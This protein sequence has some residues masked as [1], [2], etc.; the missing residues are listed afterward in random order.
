MS[1]PFDQFDTFSAPAAPARRGG[2]IDVDAIARGAQELGIDPVDLATAISYETG[3]TFDPDQWGPTTKWGRHRGLIQFGEPQ[4]AQYGVRP[5]MTVAEQM[6]AVV[7]YLRDAGVQPGMGML[8][9]YSAINAGGVGR[10]N[11]SDTAA[12][13]APGTVA[14]KVNQQMGDHRR[15]AQQLLGGIGGGG[16]GG[17]SGAMPANPF[18]QF[19]NLPATPDFGN[20]Q[21]GSRSTE[22][23]NFA[24]VKTAFNSTEVLRGLPAL[25]G[26]VLQSGNG[27][28]PARPEDREV[29][30]IYTDRRGVPRRWMGDS[31]AAGDSARETSLAEMAG[32]AGIDLVQGLTR[33]PESLLDLIGWATGGES[34]LT[35]E[36]KQA[37]EGSRQLLE[38]YKPEAYRAEQAVPVVQRDAQ[39]GIA[40]VN[41]PSGESVLGVIAQSLP[42]IPQMVATG[43]GLKSAAQGILPN[44]PRL[45]SVLGYGTANAGMVSPGI[46]EQ[47]RAEALAAGASPEEAQAVAN[48]AMA[49]AV[50]LTMATGGVGEGLA[51]AQGAGA[52]SLV[53]ALLRGA[54][55]EAPAESIEEAGTSAIGD[56]AQGRDVNQANALESGIMAAFGGGIP[57]ATVAGTEYVANRNRPA[58]LPADPATMQDIV[59]Q[60]QALAPIV[61]AEAAG[62]GAVPR[63]GEAPA[64]PPPSAP[65]VDAPQQV[66]AAAPEIAP[67]PDL[68]AATRAIDNRLAALDKAAAAQIDEAEVSALNAERQELD[69]LLREQDRA[70]REGLIQSPESRLSPDERA[71]ADAR[72]TE[73]AATLE[74]HR[75]ARTAADQADRL[76]SRLEAADTDAALY[77]VAR[78]IDPT[79]GTPQAQAFRAPT[80]EP[81]KI[82][83]APAVKEES[84]QIP[85]ASPPQAEVQPF[86][87]DLGTGQTSPNV[88]D[89]PSRPAWNVVEQTRAPV[90]SAPP[91]SAQPST[92]VSR[93]GNSTPESFA[94]ATETGTPVSPRAES[95]REPAPVQ[96][97]QQNITGA[98]TAP[99]RATSL[100]NAVTDSERVAEGRDPIIREARKGNRETVDEALTS[101]RETPTLGR[102]T[103]ARVAAGGPVELKDE[104]VLLVH[105]VDLRKRRDAAAE[106]AQSPTLDDEAR[107]AA[108][109]EYEDLVQQ[110]D[111]VD[112][113]A[114]RIGTE[115]GRLLQLRR[116]MIAEDYSLPALERKLRMVVNRELKPGEVTELREMADKVAELQR[117]LDAAESQ[118]ASAQVAE[119]LARLMKQAPGRNAT[120]A[121]RRAAAAESRAA[122]SAMAAGRGGQRSV[123]A[124]RGEPGQARAALSDRF[125]RGVIRAL[126]RDGVLKF[127]GA[128]GGSWDGA[129]I[130]I[131]DVRPENA[132]GVLLHEASHARLAEVLGP[133]AYDTALRDLDALEA[134]GD[135]TALRA[136]KRFERHEKAGFN[137]SESPDDERLA[138]LVE[139]AAKANRTTGGVS[140]KV[141]ELV[142]RLLSAFRQWA[143]TSPVFRA[144]ERIGAPRPTLQPEDFVGFAEASLRQLQRDAAQ[145]EARRLRGK[146]GALETELRTDRLTG[147]RNKRAFDEDAELGWPAV[148]AID[149][150]G[151][152]RL[153]DA[154]GHEA[155]DNVMRALADELRG[156]EGDGARFYRRSG[157]EFAAR[158][159]DP[160]DAETTMRALQDALEGMQ[161]QLDVADADGRVRSYTYEGIGISYGTGATYETADAAANRQKQTRLEAGLREQPRAD[162]P[163]RRLREDS[164]RQGGRRAGDPPAVGA[165]RSIPVDVARGLAVQ[166]SIPADPLF[167]EAVANTN[168]ATVTRDGLEIDLIRFQKEEQSG[169]TAIRTG[170]FYLPAGSANIKHYKGGKDGYGGTEKIEGR[171]L[172]K[173]PLFVKGGTGGKAPEA[174]YDLLLGKGAYQKMR[175]AALRVI[176][177]G[178]QQDIGKIEDFLESYGADSGLAY[179]IVQAS[180]TGNQ[181]PYAL[182]ENVVAHAVRNA[183]YDAVVGHSK[184]KAGAFISEIFDVREDMNPTADGDYSIHE[185]FRPQRSIPDQTQTPAFKRWFGDSKVVDDN[186]E[187]LVVY[188]G[189]PDARFMQ[190]NP[191]FM[192]MSD[193]YGQQ[194]GVGVF[195]FAKDRRAAQS[196]TDQRRAFDFQNAEPDIVPAYIKMENPLVIDAGGREWRDAQNRGKTTDVIKRA[197]AEGHDGVIIRRVRDD[198]NNNARTPAT[199]TYAVFNS[200]Q[201]KS[202]TGNR[203]TF[204]P[205]DPNIM[206]SIPEGEPDAGAPVPA[207]ADPVAFF[208][209]ARMGAFHYADGARDVAEWTRRM[210]A[211][212]GAAAGQ[213]RAMLPDAFKA[214]QAQATR[215]T[216]GQESVTEAVEAI[217]DQRRPRDVKRVVRAVVAEGMRGEDQVFEAA[218]QALDMETDAVRALF[219]QP[220]PGPRTLS[221]AQAEI[222]RL[223]KA[224]RAAQRPDPET[225]YQDQRARDFQRRISELEERIAAGDFAKRE[226]VERDL[227]ER[228]KRLQFELEKTKERFHRYA[229]EAEFQSRTPIGKIFGET[230]AGI[231]FARAIMTSLDLSA[232]LRQGG[233]ISFGHP[234]RA[235]K[236]VPGSLKAFVSEDADF[237]IRQ[238]IE[239]R[240]N[241][242]LY[243][244][245]GLE[246][247][248]IGGDALSRTEEA[249]ASRW[250]DKLP[251]YAGGGLIRGS[252]RSYT[253]FLNRLR[254]DSFDAMLA[255]LARDGSNP[256]KEEGKAIANY[257]NVAT[258]RGKV[259][260][261]EKSGEVLNTVFFAP[262][263]VASR[264]QLLAGQPLYG[265]SNRTRKMIAME[266]ARFLMGVS[267]AIGLA[268]L[269]RDED[270]E[271]KPIELDP[272]SANFG[273]VRFG[274]TFLDPLAGLAQVT[275]FLSRVASGETRT[276]TTD[277]LRPLRDQYRLTDVAPGLGDGRALGKVGYG[278]RDVPDVIASFLRSKLAPVPGAVINVATGENMIG[279]EVT[280]LS[281]AGELVTPMSVGNL[282]DVMEAQG[283]AR[284]TAINLLGILGMSVQY[285]KPDAEKLAEEQNGVL[286]AM[287]V[288]TAEDLQ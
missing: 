16:G 33:A 178:R 79:L 32:G 11:A 252:G 258:G 25:P 162:G 261:N 234:L 262:R 73:I 70:R 277:T 267:V 150:D 98:I 6:P 30:R 111:E 123:Q 240:P 109:K 171:T 202:A 269:M 231:N 196:Y 247:T 153:N 39:G 206:R 211:D 53:S 108:R 181:L 163:S 66:P 60:A 210:E 41:V 48:K 151:L 266:Y 288:G 245:F 222:E 90:T 241:A 273:K 164:P 227:I 191:V 91:A 282:V 20:V 84:T 135:A 155:A 187:P 205:A 132:V 233:K 56:I 72:R 256:T 157:D 275:V 175:D 203:G 76:R 50:P 180:K 74:R 167:Q 92:P 199:D 223:R 192:S 284:G 112:Q 259:G 43:G 10:Y 137:P 179:E 280:P 287:G 239:S 260:K 68:G 257:I 55:T 69:D 253:A 232:I 71:T 129:T 208:H 200:R 224:L 238:E 248:S 139:E 85:A 37:F 183:G 78:E 31:W 220:E 38:T 161:V 160:A 174:A 250:V 107:T 57:G 119:M 130:R 86:Q 251:A 103:A 97:G 274:D 64:A 96:S 278:G 194:E 9:V 121:E 113:A 83:K 243:K 34:L 45:A 217:G 216:R 44:S 102:E 249:Y 27:D 213:Y 116:R 124:D 169:D 254:A 209:L 14:D 154:I 127:E 17:G 272:R 128:A 101:L 49:M 133:K 279:E 188:H 201:I 165:Q 87:T 22:A 1:N 159:R 106:R 99:E 182:Q 42:Q 65:A 134:A 177:Y 67:R 193:R 148:V 82:N 114:V 184:G 265:G 51:G 115:S 2:G 18:D 5:G 230:V 283:M 58:A 242:P 270:D 12:G 24:S 190:E 29:G 218:A 63:Q 13:G 120:L 61:S 195:W 140:G 263:L 212:L 144:L 105:K 138:Y 152:K 149:M 89:I 197:K 54:A 237:R 221:E 100:K 226:R 110:I 281:A 285:R 4:R 271:T 59:A 186:G 104:A 94:P 276:T 219:V 244:R 93:N 122:L 236:A 47:A 204:D 173:R 145:P 125:G 81:G 7:A 8:D 146:I 3:G 198:Y 147:M 77:A 207:G 189:S 131:G 170:V 176:S 35:P 235:L 172:L 88:V 185:K 28:I 52:K 95:Q 141:R 143:A 225:R 62:A 118:Q 21:S 26:E 23:P 268:M 15:R 264:F 168:G 156:A 136:R 80:V 246:L 142:R 117:K 286:G 214:A 215:P 19:D 75:A 228:N 40:G 46:A 255:A 229:L 126:E 166:T 36:G 158:F